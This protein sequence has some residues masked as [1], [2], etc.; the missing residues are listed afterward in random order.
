[1]DIFTTI[2]ALQG[3]APGQLSSFI[4]VLDESGNPT[5]ASY[6]GGSGTDNLEEIASFSGKILLTGMTSSEEFPLTDNAHN[7]NFQGATMGYLTCMEQDG[8]LS[9]STFVGGGGDNDRPR[10]VTAFGEESVYIGGG[11]TSQNLGTPGV[12]QEVMGDGLM[13]SAFLARYSGEGDLQWFTYLSLGTDLP[14]IGKLA[15]SPDGSVLYV[16]GEVFYAT[17]VLENSFH[18]PTYGGGD[19]DCYLAAFSTSDGTMLWQTYFGGEGF[20]SRGGLTV[21]EDGSVYISGSTTSEES[22]ATPGAYQ[23]EPSGTGAI[24]FAAFSPEGERIWA[25]YFAGDGSEG[26]RT[27]VNWNSSLLFVGESS[28]GA[29]SG[30]LI[31]NPWDGNVSS[32]NFGSTLVGKWNIQ[33]QAPEWTTFLNPGDFCRPGH[34]AGIDENKFAV[35][36]VVLSQCA[37]FAP[38]FMFNAFQP[39]YGGGQSD[40]WYAIMQENSLGTLGSES[41]PSISLFPNP[42]RHTVTLE[43]Q[44]VY[45]GTY[46]L[47]DLTGRVVVQGRTSG[48]RTEIPLGHLPKGMYLL[49]CEAGGEVASGKLV[50]E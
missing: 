27:H 17:S 38:G 7:L 29:N 39:L 4:T 44:H 15:T 33:E 34:I 42:A 32:G 31:G 5:Y 8:T 9:W 41:Y 1:M 45:N 36:G 49:R 13:G 35:A 21:A 20:E 25:S 23:S 3:E 28:S 26:V 40:V 10:A 47:H 12:Y 48:V 50:V 22:I 2:D 37:P 16:Y 18:Q 30:I 43:M 19:R 6:F 24:F 11:T 14:T 46:T